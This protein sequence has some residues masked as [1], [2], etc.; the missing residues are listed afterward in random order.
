MLSS[1]GVKLVNYGISR[2]IH[3]NRE[4]KVPTRRY[5]DDYLAPEQLSGRGGD[6]RSDLY[7][8]GT[9]LYEMLIG[10]PPSVGRFYYPSEVH[11]EATEAV[12]ILIDHARENDP[13][14]RF[15]S[16]EAMRMEMDRITTTSL[17]GNPTQILRISLAWL[18]D[19]YKWITSRKGLPFLL[20]G[21]LILLGLSLPISI[22]VAL[23]LPARILVP[24]LVNSV[25]AGT[26]LDWVIRALARR[27]GIGSLSTSGGGIGSVY[28][29]V[30]TVNLIRLVGVSD[31]S[32]Y[33]MAD[34]LSY[35]AGTLAMTTF[36]TAFA[37]GIMMI[38]ARF[39]ERLF[40]SY[41][42][43]FYW[44]FVV[45]IILEIIMTILGQPKGLF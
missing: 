32:I 7:A 14:R 25:L 34:T 23:R 40:K 12:D 27:R 9:I 31:L 22:P 33:L 6:Q 2:L 28:G 16:A 21:L 18:T 4:T 43:G 13:D 19:R 26:L 36:E 1:S 8:M 20:V 3:L 44:S 45:I 39:T 24:M 17:S 30:L 41:T 42:A 11:L 29:W 5:M 10:H 37:L 15:P 35:F 38:T